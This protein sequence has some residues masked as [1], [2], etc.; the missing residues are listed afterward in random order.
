VASAWHIL[1]DHRQRRNYDRSLQARKFADEVERAAGILA[2]IA[3]PAVKTVFDK[4]AL[5]FIH[6]STTTIAGITSRATADVEILN[7]L[8][9]G[10]F[11]QAV[12]N[13]AFMAR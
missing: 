13:T 11:T 9:A 12:L 2:E 1:S 4:V 8:V 5:P 3:A 10:F 7:S 6:A